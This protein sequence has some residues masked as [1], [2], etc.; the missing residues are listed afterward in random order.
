M[1]A[2]QLHLSYNQTAMD[3]SRGYTVAF[4]ADG[5]KHPGTNVNTGTLYSVTCTKD[6]ITIIREGLLAI[7]LTNVFTLNSGILTE[8]ATP[9]GHNPQEMDKYKIP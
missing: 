2:S 6:A 7:P 4:I 5:A 3:H 9:Q 1:D 8:V